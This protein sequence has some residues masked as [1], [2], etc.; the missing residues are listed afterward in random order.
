MAVA[1]RPFCLMRYHAFVLCIVLLCADDAVYYHS[2]FFG[3]V[4]IFASL[5]TIW[6]DQSEFRRRFSFYVKQRW[7][8]MVSQS[9]VTFLY[10]VR[11]QWLV[12]VTVFGGIVR[13]LSGECLVCFPR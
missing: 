11:R 13:G 12:S 7:C 6:I 3:L 1:P 9:T 10:V 2:V 4:L 5:Y 8:D